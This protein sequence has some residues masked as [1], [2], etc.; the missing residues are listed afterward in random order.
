MRRLPI[1]KKDCSASQLH[2]P[3]ASDSSGTRQKILRGL[4]HK[5]LASKSLIRSETYG[6]EPVKNS[7]VAT[8]LLTSRNVDVFQKLLA[9]H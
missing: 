5:P 7:L 9:E 8:M 4:L 2:F 6:L 1:L 3:L